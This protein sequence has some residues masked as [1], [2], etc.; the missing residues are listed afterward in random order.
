MKCN[1]SFVYNMKSS[2]SNCTPKSQFSCAY[3]TIIF[4]D[5]KL[6]NSR[7]NS[8]I[9]LI[10][11]SA[12]N[13]LITLIGF[14]VSSIKKFT[15]EAIFF[16]LIISNSFIDG[17]NIKNFSLVAFSSTFSLNIAIFFRRSFTFIT[18]YIQ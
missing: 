12:F 13:S 8:F 14:G 6:V 4:L 5:N 17:H 7:S 3:H 1:T 10:T 16:P 9:S 2:N 18:S 15:N 11:C